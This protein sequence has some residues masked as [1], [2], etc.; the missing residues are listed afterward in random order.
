[1]SMNRLPYG[2][3]SVDTSKRAVPIL[4]R[5]PAAHSE[6]TGSR[7]R[8][9]VEDDPKLSTGPTSTWKCP[10]RRALENHPLEEHRTGGA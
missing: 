8:T 2:R 10:G 7:A 4:S 6:T 3:G 9:P 5:A 1:M